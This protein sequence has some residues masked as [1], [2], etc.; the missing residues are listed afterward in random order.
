MRPKR[1]PYMQKGPTELTIDPKKI[2]TNLLNTNDIA[3]HPL[4]IKSKN[5]EATFSGTKVE[6]KAQSI[7]GV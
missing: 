7:T 6:I 3:S 5:S 4:V 1:Y 2:I